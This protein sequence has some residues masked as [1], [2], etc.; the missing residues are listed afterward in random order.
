MSDNNVLTAVAIL[1]N[2]LE[3]G[4]RPEVPFLMRRIRDLLLERLAP[5]GEDNRTPTVLAESTDTATEYDDWHETEPMSHIDD[6][7]IL[8]RFKKAVRELESS[9]NPIYLDVQFL[10]KST[11]GYVIKEFSAQCAGSP[12]AWITVKSPANARPN[13]CNEYTT[14][15]VNGLDWDTGVIELDDLRTTTSELF[16]KGRRIFMKGVD[17]VTAVVQI[18]KIP[19]K[20]I[21]E[22][23]HLQTLRSLRRHVTMDD[24]CPF[25]RHL[26]QSFACAKRH[27]NALLIHHT[28][29][30]VNE[31]NKWYIN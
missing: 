12:T 20:D 14:T 10:L 4:N 5:V 21:V 31:N 1:L 27:T 24:E 13:A 19:R 17:K 30:T 9:E 25:H 2:H 18:L 16:R 3:S 11:G 22:L 29:E 7:G 8:E 15:R 28:D 26:S 6:K 23:S